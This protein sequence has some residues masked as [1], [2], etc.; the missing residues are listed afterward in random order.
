MLNNVEI[1]E[2]K[3]VGCGKCAKDCISQIIRMKN[4]KAKV[5]NQALCI[6][7]SHCVSICPEKAVSLNGEIS[8]RFKEK[9]FEIQPDKMDAF[10]KMKRS[11]RSY[12]DEAVEHEKILKVLDVGRVSPTASN[13]QPLK[14]VVVNDKKKLKEFTLL[15]LEQ[16]NKLDERILGKYKQ[17]FES[18]LLD[19]KENDIDRL[20][21]KAPAFIAIY[22]DEKTGSMV[23]VDAGI[24]SAQMTLMAE[25]LGLGSCFIGFA[26][27][28][29]NYSDKVREYLQIPKGNTVFLGMTLGYT[30]L[31]YKRAA[32]RKQLD[33]NFLK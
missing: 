10:I 25:S 23:K 7:C 24:A 26:S 33:I 31:K 11:I 15:M 8:K 16:I 13:R 28:A 32:V 1:N 27:L 3:C 20:L 14:F 9:D 6:G 17:R 18:L 5:I 12:K 2:S 21:Y 30:E 22:G 19:F 4:K 29:A